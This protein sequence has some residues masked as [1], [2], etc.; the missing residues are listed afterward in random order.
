M[1]VFISLD[2]HVCVS[3][4]CS[5]ISSKDN[6]VLGKW[7][8]NTF[9]NNLPSPVSILLY[10][11]NQPLPQICNYHAFANLIFNIKS[12]TVRT[13]S[14]QLTSRMFGISSD[15]FL[16]VLNN[17][18]VLF[19]WF[20]AAIYDVKP[21]WLSSYDWKSWTL[22]ASCWWLELWSHHISMTLSLQLKPYICRLSGK[23]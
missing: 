17:I 20:M 2:I 13:D 23:T 21:A 16:K 9:G 10:F 22:R 11:V 1:Y 3:D 14:Y 4:I 6:K 5:L 18:F 15:Y 8:K 12:D 7:R 19:M